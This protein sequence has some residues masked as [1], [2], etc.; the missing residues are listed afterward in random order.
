MVEREFSLAAVIRDT[1]TVYGELIAMPVTHAA[2]DDR[3]NVVPLRRA[4]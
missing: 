2:P 3:A 4:S 1:L